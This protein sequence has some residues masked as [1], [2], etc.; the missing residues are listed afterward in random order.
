MKSTKEKI[1]ELEN[2]EIGWDF[3]EGIPAYPHVVKITLVLEELCSDYGFDVEPHPMIDG[4]ISLCM[5][6]ANSEHCL[7]IHINYDG[8][9]D[10][11]H[12]FGLGFHYDVLED[13]ENVSFENIKQKLFELINKL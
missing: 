6:K 1:L 11:S 10:Y 9:I 5:V 7:D 4:G 3:E 2:L 12:E 13:K 8:T